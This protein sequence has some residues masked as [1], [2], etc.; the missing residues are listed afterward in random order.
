MLR[1]LTEQLKDRAPL[2]TV[3]VREAIGLLLSEGLSLEEKAEL[4]IALSAKGETP[5]EIAAFASEL[6]QRS[7][8][9]ELD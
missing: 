6:R 9:P 1:S 7:I 5:G 4:L 2:S 8:R 3:Q